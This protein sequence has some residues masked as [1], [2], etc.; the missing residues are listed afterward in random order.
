VSRRVSRLQW[1]TLGVAT[2]LLLAAPAVEA[3]GSWGDSW[4]VEVENSAVVVKGWQDAGLAGAAQDYYAISLDGENFYPARQTSYDLK[5]RGRQ[6][7]PRVEA[8]PFIPDALAAGEDTNLFIV[9]FVTQPLEAYRASLRELGVEIHK[10]LPQHSYVANVPAGVRD[11]VNALPFVR[12]MGPYH[13]AYRTEPYVFDRLVSPSE[14]LGRAIYSIRLFPSD[15]AVK[16]ELGQRIAQIGGEVEKLREGPYTMIASLS[17]NQLVRLLR[18]DEVAHA[19]R[20][21]PMENDMDIVRQVG[22]ANFLEGLPANYT[23][24]GVRGES[25]DSGFNTGHV[26]F[27]SN[28]LIEHNNVSNGSHGASTSG[29]IF[30]DGSGDP[31]GRGLMPD[32]Q[33]IVGDYDLVGLDSPGRYDYTEELLSPPYNAVFQTCSAGSPRTFLYTTTSALMDT[34]LF[35]L[36][37]LACQSQSNAG[38]QDSRPQAW[39]KNI[40]AVGGVRHKNTST[41][42]DDEWDFGGSIGP[43]EDGRV[44]PDLAH[45]YDS[46]FTPTFPSNNYTQ[47]SGTSAAT[48]IVCGHFGLFFQLWDDGIFGNTVDPDGTVFD[49]RPHMTTAKAAIVST[50]RQYNWLNGGNNGDIDRNKQGWG[51]PNLRGLY[52]VRDKVFVIDE[53]DV[54]SNL[55]STSYSLTV[56]AGAP[57]MKATMVYADPAGLPGANQHRINNLSLQV[58][59][60]SGV[61]YWGNNGLRQGLFSTPGGNENEIDTVENVFIG[62]PEAGVWTFTVIATEIVEDGHV[63]TGAVDADYALWVSGATP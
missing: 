7:D 38:N 53:S 12:W 63:E 62:E 34:I 1:A 40:V 26:D 29:I 22:G 41:A 16:A 56:P 50:A 58:T 2:A 47:F 57:L 49:N 51:L 14:T 15:D 4:Q 6:F 11:Q 32:A 28:P 54:L 18:W 45:F 19:D 13:P 46:V 3:A 8:A 61:Q 52:S 43:A 44:K 59:S 9:Q 35:D 23:G 31:A 37:L 17:D 24:Q 10:F 20:W 55:E 25:F 30:G 60:P 5:L 27:Q 42:Q 36:D 48:P 39:A 33:G 21:G